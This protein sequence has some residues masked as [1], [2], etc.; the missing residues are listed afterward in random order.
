[1]FTRMTLQRI[2]L[3]SVAL[4]GAGCASFAPGGHLN[5]SSLMNL[6]TGRG[7]CVYE[8]SLDAKRINASKAIEELFSGAGL[9]TA[10]DDDSYTV[11]WWFESSDQRVD[12]AHMPLFCSGYG[13]WRTCTRGAGATFITYQRTFQLVVREAPA[14]T[15]IGEAD[16]TA[17]DTEEPVV[18]DP[19]EG[20]VWVARIDSRG[21]STDY[22]SLI[23]NLMQPIL[24]NLGQDRENEFMRLVAPKSDDDL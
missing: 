11:E 16:S 2:S 24:A 14:V 4:L 22:S 12:H 13:Y 20:A 3:L 1:M 23:P 7:F 19:R 5:S 9:E 17:G 21:S 10:C 8:P 6:D 15:Q 18:V